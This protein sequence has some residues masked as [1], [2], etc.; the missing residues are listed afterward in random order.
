MKSGYKRP[1]VL[2]ACDGVRAVSKAGCRTER[3][4]DI[5]ENWMDD[6]G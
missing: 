6:D 2:T 3:G 4:C 5:Q 1:E